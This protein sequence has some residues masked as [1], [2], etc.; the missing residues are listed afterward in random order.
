MQAPFPYS[1]H[2]LSKLEEALSI[3]RLSTYSQLA[4]NDPEK[5]ILLYLRNIDFCS[6]LYGP[7]QTLEI[8]I[9]NAMHREF[10]G[11]YGAE[12]YD[13]P[14]LRLEHQQQAAIIDVKN[15]LRLQK[16]AVIPPQVVAS[17]SFGFWVGLLGNKYENFWR[18]HLYSTFPKL[19]RPSK[20]KDVHGSLNKI[21]RLRNRIAHHEPILN[22]NLDEDYQLILSAIAWVAPEVARWVDF[23]CP[24]NDFSL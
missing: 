12:W 5:A 21:K 1:K 19:P 9:R 6:A 13:N 16:K 22:R 24:I 11:A 7:L 2:M 14:S 3:D 17:L 10:S 20:R 15:S 4:G 23:H 18:P 8:V